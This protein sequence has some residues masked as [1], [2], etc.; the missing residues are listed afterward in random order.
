VFHPEW[1]GWLIIDEIRKT[2]PN[3]FKEKLKT[4]TKLESLVLDFYKNTF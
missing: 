1:P 4:N 2:Y 3:E